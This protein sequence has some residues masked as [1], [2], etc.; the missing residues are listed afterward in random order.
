MKKEKIE[1]FVMQSEGFRDTDSRD[2][3][4]RELRAEGAKH[5]SRYSTYEGGKSLWVVVYAE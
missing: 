4:F 1:T 3:R 5:I 2:A